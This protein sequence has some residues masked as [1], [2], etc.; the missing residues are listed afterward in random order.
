M[1]IDIF[2]LQKHKSLFFDIYDVVNEY[3]YSGIQF[4]KHNINSKSGNLECQMC[5]KV[6]VYITNENKCPSCSYKTHN[7]KCDDCFRHISCISCGGKS[8]KMI[9]VDHKVLCRNNRCLMPFGYFI[10]Y[11]YSRCS[12]NI[13]SQVGICQDLQFYVDKFM[14]KNKTCWDKKRLLPDLTSTDPFNCTHCILNTKYKD[15]SNCPIYK[16]NTLTCNCY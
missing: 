10:N 14:V 13:L 9:K 6:T 2:I 12:C 15:V 5:G 1:S 11:K 4:I 8:D 7:L 16:Y 3:D